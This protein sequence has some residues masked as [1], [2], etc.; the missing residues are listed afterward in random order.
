[1]R[2]PLQSIVEF[3]FYGLK[4]TETWKKFF[5]SVAPPECFNAKYNKK[6]NREVCELIGYPDFDQMLDL[7]DGYG[8]PLMLM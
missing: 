7:A 2:I 8:I 6:Y 5:E 4:S 3:E 1:M